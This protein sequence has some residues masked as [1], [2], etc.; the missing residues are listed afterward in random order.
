MHAVFNQDTSTN[1]RMEGYTNTD[2]T[3]N[4]D[5]DT[6]TDTDMDSNTHIISLLVLLKQN[7]FG[8]WQKPGCQFFI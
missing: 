5:T 3:D 7:L 8:R 6:Y 2:N 1:T 4:A